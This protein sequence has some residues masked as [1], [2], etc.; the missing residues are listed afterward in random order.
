VKTLPEP[1]DRSPQSHSAT[2]WRTLLALGPAFVVVLLG[3]ATFYGFRGA[4]TSREAVIH[5]R[6][7]IETTQAVLSDI[8][9]AETGE[10]GFI[11]TGD[12]SYLEPYTKGL[13]ALHADSA[14]LRRL[15]VDNRTQQLRLD[16]L[17]FLIGKRLATLAEGVASRRSRGL[18]SAADVVRNGRGRELMNDV[19]V[20]LANINTTEQALLESRR[21][22]QTRREKIVSLLII[23]G[24]IV[25]V[26]LALAINGML[27]RS[28]EAEAR[29]AR[30]VETRN[31]Q[32]EEQNIELEQQSTQL[33][34]QA[35][36]LEMQNEELQSASETLADQA[37][38]LEM[39]AEQLEATIRA[40][41]EESRV[42]EAARAAAELANRA[43]SDF[44]A[45]MSHELRT[46]LNAIAGYAQ[47]MQLGVPEPVPTAHLEY[48][49]RI[50]QSQRHL[51]GVINSVLNFARI[52]A[53]SVAYE[54]RDVQIAALLAEVEP[55]VA[56]QMQTRGHKYKCLTPDP[57]L[58]VRAD[59]DKARQILLNLLSNAIKF[60]PTAG[61]ITLSAE[62]LI[63]DPGEK[64]AA[65]RVSD[66][67]LGVP[68]DKITTIF[69]P[70]VQVESS[71][72]RTAEGTG[73]GLAISR[74]LARGMGG[75]LVVESVLGRGSTFTLTLPRSKPARVEIAPA[76]ELVKADTVA[77]S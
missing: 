46:P 8:Q 7:V 23:V 40:L 1:Q 62:A 25:A 64:L 58:V 76:D 57:K 32:L 28:A 47:L 68:S 72:N 9:N 34:D 38:E 3:I 50:Q 41:D 54:I 66:T 31:Q 55:L 35:A 44:L 42:A 18:D 4:V 12:E 11:I 48:L 27:F 70:F 21:A 51:L 24:T 10:R 49:T 67:G 53:G 6:D 39:Q 19:R 13:A 56:P 74:E 20:R 69:D 60:T 15:T 30:D 33:Q 75:D 37:A 16:T 65:I 36:E 71:H 43:K 61:E 17:A 14:Q 22:A 29:L 52:E 59:P 45:T 73:L 26:I 5:T 77:S 2:R 63:D